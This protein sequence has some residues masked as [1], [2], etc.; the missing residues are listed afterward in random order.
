MGTRELLPTFAHLTDRVKLD[1]DTDVF[2]LG[3]IMYDLIFDVRIVDMSVNWQFI[4]TKAQKIKNRKFSVQM[5][6]IEDKVFDVFRDMCRESQIGKEIL[7][8][9]KFD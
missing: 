3:V 4:E 7:N 8:D 5:D 6:L 1:Q 2:A 9:P